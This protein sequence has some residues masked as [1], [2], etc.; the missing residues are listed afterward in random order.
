MAWLA[1]LV[2]HQCLC[3]LLIDCR[4]GG[5]QILKSSQLSVIVWKSQTIMKA[6]AV[7]GSPTGLEL[8]ECICATR[9][10]KTKNLW[11]VDTPMSEYIVVRNILLCLCSVMNDW[12]KLTFVD[13]YSSSRTSDKVGC[14]WTA[15]FMSCGSRI[16]RNLKLGILNNIHANTSIHVPE[17]GCPMRWH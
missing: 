9:V 4:V 12:L 8:W 16:H 11:D 3:W 17:L 13:L 10:K 2:R 5:Y 6:Y 14:A 15:N 7:T 1:V